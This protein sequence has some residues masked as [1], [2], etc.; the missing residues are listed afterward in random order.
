MIRGP[1][2]SL[3]GFGAQTDARIQRRRQQVVDHVEALLAAGIIH[4][5]DIGQI[6]EAAARIVAQEADDVD[7]LLGVYR[8]GKLIERDNMIDRST[9]KRANN[10]LTQSV[11][12][13]VVHSK[14]LAF[15]GTGAPDFLLQQHAPYRSASAVGG[16]PGT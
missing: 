5:G 12:P 10:R 2:R 1:L 16:R 11:E 14:T 8:H 13:A 6:D 4:R 7:N 15:D 3:V 9:R